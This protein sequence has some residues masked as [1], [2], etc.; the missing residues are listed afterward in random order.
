MVRWPAAAEEQE[1]QEEESESWS[2]KFSN[3]LTSTYGQLQS[4]AGK[5]VGVPQGE[6]WRTALRAAAR[7]GTAQVTCL[8]LSAGLGLECLAAHS[9]QDAHT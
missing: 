4:A 8:G 6:A 3:L 7:S 5:V 2:D 9:C 1:S